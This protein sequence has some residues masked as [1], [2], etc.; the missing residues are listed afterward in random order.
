MERE[1]RAPRH[2]PQAGFTLVE[3][4]TAVVILVFGLI[5]VTNLFII[6]GSSNSVAN[7]STAA[8][9]I[10]SQVLEDLKATTYEDLAP[11]GSLDANDAGYSRE[12]DVPGVGQIRTRWVITAVGG[13]PTILRIQVQAEGTGALTGA[14]SRADFTTFRSCT[15]IEAGCPAATTP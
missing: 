13:D 3:V 5:A 11:G 8:T 2:D 12:D 1:N 10:A 9:G 15:D 4:L 14:R 6:A 7:A